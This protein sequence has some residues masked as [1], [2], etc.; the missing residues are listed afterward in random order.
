MNVL[1]TGGA[2]F[3]G[4]HVSRA[5]LGEGHA[6][7]ILDNLSA[8]TPENIPDECVLH[9]AD[10]RSK[11]AA[12]LFEK[13]QFPVMIHLAAQMDVRKSVAD[14]A[15]DA[16]VN[17]KGLLNLME[18]GKDHGLKKVV[19]SSTGGA[20]YGDP[21]FAP[22]SEAHPLNPLS[23]YGIT[24][25]VSE[26]YLA[27]YQNEYGIEYISLRFG[28]VYG[29]RQNPHGEAGVVAI[30][31]KKI[32]A[33]EA[34]T[35]FGDGDQT[36]DYVYVGDVARA[37]LSA[38]SCTE[39]GVYNI[40]T[41]IETSV[42]RLFEGLRDLVDPQMQA[43]HAPGKPGEQRRSVLDIALIHEKMNWKPEVSLEEGLSRTLDWFRKSVTA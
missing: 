3:I 5:L 37:C 16:D 30:F 21:V 1:L 17:V 22:Q 35:I 25:L 40:G 11:E 36:R 34:P 14:P 2:G 6:V 42:N 10:I 38:L 12:R 29:P 26:K 27:F 32:L 33:G 8:G 28:N 15:F 23:P 39:S 43:H 24:K 18:A 9:E 19:F 4:A 31:A 41:G 7:H 20:I 13:F